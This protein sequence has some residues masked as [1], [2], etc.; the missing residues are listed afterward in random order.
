[1]MNS[2]CFMGSLEKLGGYFSK[3]EL[4]HKDRF[5]GLLLIHDLSGEIN[6]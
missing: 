5:C 4:P 2:L 3:I 1:M 6:K